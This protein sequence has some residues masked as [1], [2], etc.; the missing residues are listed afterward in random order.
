[1]EEPDVSFLAG[2]AK[3]LYWLGKLFEVNVHCCTA[4]LVSLMHN[5]ISLDYVKACLSTRVIVTF[6]TIDL[7]EYVLNKCVIAECKELHCIDAEDVVDGPFDAPINTA[8][9]PVK[10]NFLED[11][12]SHE[13]Q[14]NHILVWMVSNQNS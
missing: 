12:T 2:L 14:D 13:Q 9:Q 5:K 10:N 3:V 4:N 8:N 6:L 11:Q 7:A 1:M